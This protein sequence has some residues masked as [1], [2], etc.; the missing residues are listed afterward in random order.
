[1]HIMSTNFAKTLVWKHGNDVNLW[2]HK[3][4]TPNANDH[5]TTL[6]QTPPMKIFCVRHCCVQTCCR[7]FLFLIDLEA[8]REQ[9]FH[10]VKR[11]EQEYPEDVDRSLVDELTTFHLHVKQSYAEKGSFNH[12]RLYQILKHEKIQAVFPNVETILRLYLCLMV[13]N[14]SGERSFSKLKRIIS[15]L[16]ST[17]SQE[18]SDW[19]FFA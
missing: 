5:H 11:L 2:R 6:N 17:M 12:Q 19:V 18:L 13:T 1:M 4:R 7:S 14:C 8:S 3:Q 9:V 15:V 10:G 16:R